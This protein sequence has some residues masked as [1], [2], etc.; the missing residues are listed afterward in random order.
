MKRANLIRGLIILAIAAFFGYRYGQLGS[1]I[2]PV[3]IIV[4]AGIGLLSLVDRLPPRW[5]NMMLNLAIS[6][7]FL[8]FVFADINLVEVG[9]ALAQANYWMLVPSTIFVYVHLYFRTLRA[10]WL[11]KPMGHAP[12]WPTF[13]ALVIG[14]T[15]NVVL[16]ARAGEFLRAY[17]QGRSC[18]LSKTGAF[19]ALV[20]ERILDGLTVLL[21]LVGV[22]ALGVRN[23]VLQ[24][25]GMAGAV[26]YVGALAALV[27]FLLKRHWADTLI[28][29]LLPQNLA[30]LALKI[31]DGFTGGLAI[32]KNPPH[33]AMVLLW[34]VFTW[35]PIPLAFWF[36]LKAFDFGAPLPWQTSVLMLPAMAL[37]LT[38][39]G[40]PAGVGL[41]QFAAKLTLDSTFA[42]LPVAPNFAETVAAA[43]IILHLSQ[44]IPEVIAGVISFM[45]EGLSTKDIDAGRSMA[46]T[47]Y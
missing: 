44:F 24:Q 33:L 42:G 5:Q 46:P 6:F 4:F 38:I 12:F 36:A 37:A 30:Q 39:P 34:N 28:A 27:V 21:V 40:A 19:A 41:V 3:Y 22:I 10:Q 35:I 7:F 32:L 1:V 43:T 9:Q 26:L 45:V 17:V 18:G 13:R 2:Y 15:A 31:L 20:V 47:K 8:D 29:K 16:P 14:I 25:A 23:E 11:L